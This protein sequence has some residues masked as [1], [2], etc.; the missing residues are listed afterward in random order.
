MVEKE[1]KKIT[2]LFSDSSSDCSSDEEDNL[3]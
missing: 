1:E 2:S 3:D